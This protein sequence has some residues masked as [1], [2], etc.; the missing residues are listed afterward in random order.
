M[1]VDFAFLCRKQ[2]SI[3]LKIFFCYSQEW[4]RHFPLGLTLITVGK[5]WPPFSHFGTEKWNLTG[6]SLSFQPDKVSRCDLFFFSF[7]DFQWDRFSNIQAINNQF[8]LRK[9]T[10]MVDGTFRSLQMKIPRGILSFG[11]DL[12][13]PLIF[14]HD[15]ALKYAFLSSMKIT[16]SIHT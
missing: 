15:F 13:N 14:S 6:H 7:W 4:I 12:L 1:L 9:V 2:N 3:K 16:G 5:K 8:E 11:F 10:P